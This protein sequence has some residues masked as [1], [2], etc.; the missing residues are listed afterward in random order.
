MQRSATVTRLF[1]TGRIA[2]AEQQYLLERMARN[3]GVSERRVVELYGKPDLPPEP[4]VVYLLAGDVPPVY[5]QPVKIGFSRNLRLR[6]ETLQMGCPF[7]LMLVAFVYGGRDMER[8]IHAELAAHRIREDWFFMCDDVGTAF[9][10]RI[11]QQAREL[12][13]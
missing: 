6:I 9:E 1:R 12:A 5:G 8:E 13:A 3:L 7:K 10:S 11:E 4:E 2:R